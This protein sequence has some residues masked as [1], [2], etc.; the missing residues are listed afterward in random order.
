MGQ[1]SEQA[2]KVYY[3][4][5]QFQAEAARSRFWGIVVEY[6]LPAREEQ[7]ARRD[8]GGG[9]GERQGGKIIEY[10]F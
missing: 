8:R 7:S 3:C 10:T 6:N 2:K 4:R 1:Q 9:Y 5:F